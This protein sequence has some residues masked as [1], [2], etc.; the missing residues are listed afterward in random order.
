MIVVHSCKRMFVLYARGKAGCGS[1]H[2]Q[3]AC[4]KAELAPVGDHGQQP[5]LEQLHGVHGADEARLVRERVGAVRTARPHREGVG[6]GEEEHEPHGEVDGG[7]G[8][9]GVDEEADAAV[10]PR[11]Q[12]EPVEPR[13]KAVHVP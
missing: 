2:L 13:P 9:R 8:E 7:H 5:Q 12:P 11:H 3:E 4:L 1:A 10:V 6:E